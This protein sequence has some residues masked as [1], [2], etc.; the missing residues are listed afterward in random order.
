MAKRELTYRGHTAEELQKMSEE[1]VMRILTARARRTLKRGLTDQQETLLDRVRKARAA[2]PQK[3][4]IRTHVRDM[5]ILPEFV[6]LRFAVYNGKEYTEF[7][8]NTEMIGHY[9]AEFTYC[10]RP[11]K[12]SAPGVGATRSSLFVPIK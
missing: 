1:E 8:V 9:L 6:G 4:P 2:M 5:V 11:V 3:K 12:H 10:R 7:E